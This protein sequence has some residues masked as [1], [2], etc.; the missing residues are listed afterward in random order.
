MQITVSL[1][2]PLIAPLLTHYHRALRTLCQRHP[3]AFILELLNLFTTGF[4]LTTGFV[5]YFTSGVLSQAEP[6]GNQ[7]IFS[8]S[9]T[10][11]VIGLSYNIPPAGCVK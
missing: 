8:S 6:K 5:S 11:S 1:P 3:T 4:V 10:D 9:A 7:L 2:C